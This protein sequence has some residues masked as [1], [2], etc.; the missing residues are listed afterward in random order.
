MELHH[1]M[2][3]VD[4]ITSIA[5]HPAIGIARVGNSPHDYFLGPQIPGHH[6]SDPT[7]FRDA[8]GR[9]KRQGVE[10]RLFGY[11]AAGNLVR[12][13]TSDDGAITWTVHIANK[14]A[15]W[16]QF[17]QALDIPASMGKLPKYKAVTNPRRNKSIEGQ[18]RDGLVIDPGPHSISGCNTNVKGTDPAY[19]LD[20]GRFMG[21]NVYLGEL[22]TNKSGN[23]IFLGGRGESAAYD[24]QP[25]PGF[26]NNP[27]WHDDT[28]DGSV[29]A[30]I[31]LN[32]RSIQATGAWV[33]TAPPNYAPG[34]QAFVTGYD[35]LY[36]V[37]VQ[38]L[39]Q[40]EAPSKPGFFKHIWPI[41]ERVT[42]NQ[43][44]NAGVA[45]DYGWGSP[46]DFTHETLIERLG[47]SDAESR[48][49]RQAIFARFRNP[50]YKIVQGGS[51]LPPLYGDHVTLDAETRDPREWVAIPQTHYTFL[52]QWAE[53]HFTMDEPEP[54]YKH[55]DDMPPTDRPE[56]LDKAMLEETLGGPFH[57]GCEF[58]W[59]MRH[60]MMYAAPFRIKRRTT[61]EA[62]YGPELTSDI[63]LAPDGPLNGS[64][65]GDV[66][67]WM[68]TPWQTDTASCLSSYVTYGGEYLPT[69]WPARVP[70]DVLTESNYQILL[71]EQAT[72]SE[73]EQAFSFHQR[74]KWLRGISYNNEVPP[75]MTTTDKTRHEFVSDW[76][77]FGVVVRKPL[78]IE[79]EPLFPRHVWVE[80][81][82]TYQEQQ[83]EG[84]ALANASDLPLKHN[85]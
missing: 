73:K 34:V 1:A 76:P 67:R 35:L 20:N 27:G 37:A 30:T 8:Q 36:D 50:D 41:L 15:A 43:W 10:F 78:P 62:D 13:L 42:L 46:S 64:T 60:G 52:Q 54:V 12:E 77:K 40:I 85:R 56:A 38:Q 72:A 81:G 11:D 18:D 17:S 84:V 33:V 75:Q 48:A 58:T 74:R 47:N 51:L 83:K 44:V 5:I 49:L 19:A 16:Y 80:T 9:I 22:R 68:A 69:F 66:T 39:H 4:E 6:P 79:D 61:P 23:L 59:P 26:G 71:S 70:N 24:N 28:S 32:G 2:S 63:A 7:D 31:E 45:R 21:K 55:V 82:R 65:P 14:K 29:D 3:T 53:G 57:P 25:T